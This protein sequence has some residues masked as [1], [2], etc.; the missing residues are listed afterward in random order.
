MAVGPADELMPRGE[1]HAPDGT[2][3]P[4]DTLPPDDRELDEALEESFPASD[5]PATWSGAD[6]DPRRRS[7]VTGGNRG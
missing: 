7:A 5:P 4:D 2:L 1:T 6:Q 3:A